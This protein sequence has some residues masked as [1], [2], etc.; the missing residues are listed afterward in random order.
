MATVFGLLRRTEALS[1]LTNQWMMIVIIQVRP[2]KILSKLPLGL[3]E[4][5]RRITV[6]QC[7]EGL[8]DGWNVMLLEELDVLVHLCASL[9]FR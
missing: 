3:E 7:T 8:S 6:F 9:R 2:C 4:R 5:K 1:E